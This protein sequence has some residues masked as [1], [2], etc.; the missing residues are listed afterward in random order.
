M[1][2]RNFM[3]LVIDTNIFIS[4]LI[5]DSLT[6]YLI[7]NSSFSLFIPEQELIEIKKYEKLISRKSGQFSNEVRYLIRKLLKY[8]AVLQN[9]VLLKY[10]EH[11]NKIM[12][13]IDKADV[14]FIAA[15]LALN[16]PIWS[17]DKHFK[18]QKKIEIFTTEELYKMYF[19]KK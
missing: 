15:A 4:S 9:D 7:L 11:A 10:R 14:P 13:K 8:V 16:C 12:G 17:N 6:R 18:K 1:L 5:K 2:P 19:N 3:N